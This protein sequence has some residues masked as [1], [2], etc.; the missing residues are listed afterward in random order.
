MFLQSWTDVLRTLLVGGLAYLALLLFVRISGKRTLSSM[1]AFDFIVTVALGSTLATILLSS[2]V[3]LAEGISA[4]LILIAMQYTI[5]WLSVHTTIVPRL[6][7]S[8]PTLLALRGELLREAMAEQ[9]VTESEVFQAVRQ[10]GLPD[11]GSTYAVVLE[12]DGQFSVIQAQPS[13]DPGALPFVD[14]AQAKDGGERV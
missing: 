3:A 14:E 11:V 13:G 9:R 1:N 6:V 5:T 12:T 8:T 7:K 2:D 10:A 4:F